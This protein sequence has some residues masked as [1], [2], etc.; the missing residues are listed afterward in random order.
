MAGL[1]CDLVEDGA[2]AVA[3]AKED[4]RRYGVIFMDR[5]MPNMVSPP[6]VFCFAMFV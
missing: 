3:Q 4:I 1:E 5:M 6:I 2:Q